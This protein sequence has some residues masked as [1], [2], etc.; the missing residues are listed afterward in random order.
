MLRIVTFKWAPAPVYRSK[1]EAKHVNVMAAMVQRFYRA[2]HEFICITDDA[3]G[4][5]PHIRAIPLWSDHSDLPNPNGPQ[6]PSCYRRLKLFGPEAAQLI[7]ERFVMLDLDCVIV[8]DMRPVW[9][10][11]EDFVILKSAH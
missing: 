8:G 1:F 6:F 5:L 7:G 4:L 10:R 3:D 2:P 11:P 9:D